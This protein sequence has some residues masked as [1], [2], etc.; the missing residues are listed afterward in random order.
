MLAW[1]ITKEKGG[2]DK[3]AHLE[4]NTPVEF[5]VLN[6]QNANCKTTG[7]QLIRNCVRSLK[8]GKA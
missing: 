5:Q 7:S 3:P 6:N 2:K 4:C 8:K 1:K